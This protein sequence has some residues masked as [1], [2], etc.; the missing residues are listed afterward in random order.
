MARRFIGQ[1]TVYVTY[2]GSFVGMDRYQGSA[3]GGGV[4]YSATVEMPECRAHRSDTPGMLDK[5]A[6]LLLDRAVATTEDPASPDA[7]TANALLMA[8][9]ASRGWDVSGKKPEYRMRRA[10]AGS[11]RRVAAAD[12]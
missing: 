11:F 12:F 10:P 7:G 2:L 3:V 6:A 5:A 1:V 8:S 9:L 4:S